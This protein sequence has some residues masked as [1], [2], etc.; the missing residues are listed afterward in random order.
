LAL[1][2]L[3]GSFDK[4]LLV[5]STGRK[6]IATLTEYAEVRR[7]A[8]EGASVRAIAAEVFGDVRF[9][10]RGRVGGAAAAPPLPRR[11]LCLRPAHT[12]LSKSQSALAGDLAPAPNGVS[13]ARQSTRYGGVIN[14]LRSAMLRTQGVAG[15]DAA[16]PSYGQ[17]EQ[18]LVGRVRAADSA[19]EKQGLERNYC[20][21]MRLRTN[22]AVSAASLA[23]YLRRCECIVEVIDLRIIE[24][25]A[26]PQ[27]F[28]ARYADVELEGYLSVWE[29]MHPDSSI[30][31]LAPLARAEGI[32]S[33][34]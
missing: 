33:E 30:E 9:R 18:E 23:D 24:A 8:R 4:W 11:A 13:E 21:G 29:A 7:L 20:G 12:A 10:G 14:P 2:V 25:T 6:K 31:R 1:K 17:G 28:A 27:S 5:G 16:E 34:P 32:H 3:P 26:R 19:H 15:L 22:T